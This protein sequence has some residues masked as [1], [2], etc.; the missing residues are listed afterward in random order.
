MSGAQRHA[1]TAQLQQQLVTHC[2]G[3]GSDFVDGVY[4][5]QTRD[6]VIEFQRAYGL[7]VDGYFG[8]ATQDA[9]EG[10]VNGSCA[11]D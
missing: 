5:N 11:I 1:A 9:L 8:P 2:A 4:G 7:P 10:P 6:V 3:L